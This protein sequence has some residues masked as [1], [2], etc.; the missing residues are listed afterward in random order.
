M[1]WTFKV[2][3]EQWRERAQEVVRYTARQAIVYISDAM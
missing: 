2:Y 3:P 1:N